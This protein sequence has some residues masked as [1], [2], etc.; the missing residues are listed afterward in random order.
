MVH[1]LT[2]KGAAIRITLAI[3]LVL[4]TYNPSGYSL[5]HWLAVE[6]FTV[7]PG[8]VLALVILLIGWVACLRTALVSLGWFGMG[9]GVAVFAAVVWL[10]I[11]YGLLS[12]D[13]T[14]VVWLSLVIIGIILGVGLTWSLVRARVTGHIEVQ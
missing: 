1:A 12:L 11:D 8:Q 13:G 9:L 5:Y 3:L 4:L 7:G 2:A 6:P 10:L 14:G